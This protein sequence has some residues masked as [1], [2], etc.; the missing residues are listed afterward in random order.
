[1]YNY[2]AGKS[3]D[4]GKIVAVVV[5][6]AAVIIGIIIIIVVYCWEKIHNLSMELMTI[7]KLLYMC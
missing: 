7:I 1:M 6:A 3:D 2:F 5:G 4:R